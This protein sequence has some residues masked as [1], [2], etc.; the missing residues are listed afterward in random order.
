MLAGPGRRNPVMA[1]ALLI[2]QAKPLGHLSSEGWQPS[3]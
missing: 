1:V 3:A 2:A